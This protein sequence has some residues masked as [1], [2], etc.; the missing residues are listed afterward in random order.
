MKKQCS[1]DYSL[2]REQLIK[3]GGTL[4][5]SK[6]EGERE[7]GTGQDATLIMSLKVSLKNFTLSCAD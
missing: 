7:A 5:V 6:E 2:D 4:E 1:K 3:V